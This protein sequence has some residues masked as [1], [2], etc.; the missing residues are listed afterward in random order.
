MT[1]T[2]TPDAARVE[3]NPSGSP[4]A[5]LDT[6]GLIAVAGWAYSVAIGLSACLLFT[7]ELMVGLLLLPLLG[8]APSVWATTLG[9]FQLIL[10]LGY[11][12]AHVSVT[13]LGRLG[14]IFHLI[15]AGVAVAALVFGPKMADIHFDSMHPVLQVLL[16]LAVAVGLPSFVLCA[17][18]PLLS[19]WLATAAFRPGKAMRGAGKDPYRLYVVSNAGS[20]LALLAYPLLNRAGPGAGRSAPRLG[21]RLRRSCSCCWR[22]VGIAP[23]HGGGRVAHGRRRSDAGGNDAG[24][25]DAVGSDAGST[26]NRSRLRR[27]AWP[28]GSSWP[29]Y[30]AA[31]SRP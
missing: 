10:L 21:R 18:T 11:L 28:A 6:S 23:R 4:S 8:G 29:P 26:S 9:F 3:P 31:S 27:G 2:P 12:Y 7:L 17:T 1:A 20:L 30:R 25:N 13:R 24:R 15:L 22:S 14:P 16:T 5:A 19:A